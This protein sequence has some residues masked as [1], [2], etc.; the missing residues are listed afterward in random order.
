[1]RSS[2][3]CIQVNV[4]FILLLLYLFMSFTTMTPKKAK[5]AL[6]NK[7]MSLLSSPLFGTKISTNQQYNT[8]NNS[9]CDSGIA[10]L[11]TTIE[12]RQDQGN[13]GTPANVCLSCDNESSAMLPSLVQKEAASWLDELHATLDELHFMSVCTRPSLHSRINHDCSLYR[14]CSPPVFGWMLSLILFC[15]ALSNLL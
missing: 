5:E 3:C 11:K 1:M 12:N 15:L 2:Q 13:H 4:A 6:L 8:M 10:T 7:D 14:C 9:K